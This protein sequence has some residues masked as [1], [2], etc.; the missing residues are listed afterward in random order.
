MLLKAARSCGL[1]LATSWMIGD[2]DSDIQAGK[3]V[4]C[5]TAWL[6]ARVRGRQM[7]PSAQTEPALSHFP[8]SLL[9]FSVLDIPEKEI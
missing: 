3:N 5:W 6:S 9:K 4:G 8:R 1:G 2:S 7:K